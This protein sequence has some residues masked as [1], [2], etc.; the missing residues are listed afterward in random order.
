[1]LWSRQYCAFIRLGTGWGVGDLF[2]SKI[3][4]QEHQINSNGY[5]TDE[6]MDDQ[7]GRDVHS[8]AEVYQACSSRCC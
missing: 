6:Q 5:V 8:Y 3:H 7:A 2:N 4:L 1:M